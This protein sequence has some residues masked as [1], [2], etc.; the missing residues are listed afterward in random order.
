MEVNIRSALREDLPEILNI[1]NEAVRSTAGTY[2]SEPHTLEQR[3]VWFERCESKGYPILVATQG[4]ALL[5]WGSLGP[6]M[7]RP[8]FKHTGVCSVY[9]T[10]TARG[11]GI[12][13]KLIEAMIIEAR[14]RDLHT[15]LAAVDASNDASLRLHEKLGFSRVGTFQEVGRRGG[16]WHDMVYLQRML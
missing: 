7:E 8:G 13:T 5:G 1:Y 4:E 10:S 9:V 12:G 16:L 14:S 3:T 15:M 11:R 6:F 2:D